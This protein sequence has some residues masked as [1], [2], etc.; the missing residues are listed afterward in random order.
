MAHA[1]EMPSHCEVLI[2]HPRLT[3]RDGPYS[4]QIT[5]QGEHS[6]YSVTDGVKTISEPILYCFGRGVTGQTYVFRHNNTLYESRVSYFQE[7]QSLDITIGQTRFV[8]TSVEDAIGRPIGLGEVLPSR[9]PSCSW[10]VITF[11]SPLC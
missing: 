6:I 3:F 1:L 5:A 2:K 4:Y 9:S 8:P 10:V 11:G 7:L